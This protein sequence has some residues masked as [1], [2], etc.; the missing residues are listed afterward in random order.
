VLSKKTPHSIYIFPGF[1]SFIQ[2]MDYISS[3]LQRLELFKTVHTIKPLSGGCIS[4][5]ARFSTDT[6]DYFIK[7]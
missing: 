6:G 2:T 7:V 5:A 1:S 4:Q 3:K